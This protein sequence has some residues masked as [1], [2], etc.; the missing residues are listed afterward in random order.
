MAELGYKR[1]NARTI[2]KILLDAN[3]STS[4]KIDDEYKT[5]LIALW[6]GP[7]P[8]GTDSW[9][10]RLVAEKMNELGYGR[11]DLMAIS[12][13]LKQANITVSRNHD[14]EFKAKVIALRKGPPPDGAE[15]WSLRL[16][17]K[18]MTE[19]GYRHPDLMAISN[20]LKQ[21]NIYDEPIYGDEFRAKLIELYNGPPPDGTFKWSLESLADKMA[22]MGY[23]RPATTTVSSFLKKANIFATPIYGDEFKA[24]LLS[25]CDGPPP[26]GASRWTPAMLADKMAE[27]GYKRPNV[28]TVRTILTK[29]NKSISPRITHEFKAKLISLASGP[30]PDGARNWT[31]K[32]LANKMAE[33]GYKRP[34]KA[35]VFYILKKANISTSTTPI[36]DD[37]FKAKIL[38]LASGPPPDGA[39]RWSYN[40]L[41]DKMAELGYKR[42]ASMTVFYILKKANI[43]TSPVPVCDK[44]LPV[45]TD[46]N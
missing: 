24:K 4:R 7:P 36:Y 20:I 35:T 16:L 25:L 23:K 15:R 27:M 13:I 5:K 19:L 34:Y 32:M 29:S 22:E 31:L 43:S 26:D 1:L 12:N 18:K 30:P 39:S 46:H 40:S 14:D 37:E 9:S 11:R 21:A 33:L 10:V 2:A 6:N 17:A 41:A 44:T 3:K 45:L 42:P 28:V 38:S 8:D